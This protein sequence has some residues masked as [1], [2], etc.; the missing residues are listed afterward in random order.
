VAAPYAGAGV[1][2]EKDSRCGHLPRITPEC[3]GF[4]AGLEMRPIEESSRV[5]GEGVEAR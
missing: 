4:R 1:D 5:A 2:D 3:G